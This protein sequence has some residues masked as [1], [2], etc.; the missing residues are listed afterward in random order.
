MIDLFRRWDVDHDGTISRAEFR[1]GIQTIGFDASPTD[2]DAIF[3]D[4]DLD[5]SYA[6]GD[7]ERLHPFTSLA[8]PT[9]LNV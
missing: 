9:R 7:L 4:I 8:L 3:D 5:G 2:I 6:A 1:Q